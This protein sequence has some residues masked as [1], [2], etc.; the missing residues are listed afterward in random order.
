[1]SLRHLRF[2]PCHNPQ[3]IATEVS[4]VTRIRHPTLTVLCAPSAGARDLTGSSSR[5]FAWQ[6]M[7][8]PHPLRARRALHA[9]R[10]HR[11][12]NHS[13]E[14]SELALAWTGQHNQLE[15]QYNSR[16]KGSLSVASSPVPRNWEQAQCSATVRLGANDEAVISPPANGVTPES[17]CGLSAAEASS[18]LKL[19]RALKIDSVSLLPVDPSWTQ[20][21]LEIGFQGGGHGP[22]E[23]PYGLIYIPS[24]EPMNLLNAT[25]GGPGPGFSKLDQLGGRWLYFESA[26]R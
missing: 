5:R 7:D 12:S 9:L 24:S 11:L 1:L 4:L 2:V 8:R 10:R 19:C 6:T 17:V 15:V 22:R 25:T 18:L 13:S 20:R 23:W 14:L 21:Y 3:P 26:G 16:D